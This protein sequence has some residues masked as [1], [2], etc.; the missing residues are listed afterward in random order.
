[1]EQWIPACCRNE[2][3]AQEKVYRHYFDAM[4]R[5]VRRYTQDED[6]I[7]SIVN[8]GFLRVFKKI[9]KYNFT[10]SF[11][12]WVRTIVF[13]AVSDYFKR[14]RNQFKLVPMLDHDSVNDNEGLTDL[15]YEDLVDTLKNVPEM[16][17]KVFEM[18]AIQGYKHAEIA[19]ALS[20]SEGTS[21]WHVSNARSRIQELLKK[22][23]NRKYVQ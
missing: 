4:V 9:D 15:Y 7:M 6:D 1:L 12:A 16:S 13:H 20:I 2:R 18:F 21:K 22:R 17:R 14:Q 3:Q 11:E 23:K 10:G 19:E 8:N 5:L